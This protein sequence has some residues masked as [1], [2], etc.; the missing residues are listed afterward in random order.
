MSKA[1]F[2]QTEEE[3]IELI[4]QARQ[5][6]AQGGMTEFEEFMTEKVKEMQ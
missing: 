1:M 2:A 6:Y 5:L 4:D 3:A